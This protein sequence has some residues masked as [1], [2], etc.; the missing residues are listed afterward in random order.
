MMMMVRFPNYDDGVGILNNFQV[1]YL[2]I[3]GQERERGALLD[4]AQVIKNH[5]Q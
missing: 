4:R 2:A 5:H 1:G 3:I